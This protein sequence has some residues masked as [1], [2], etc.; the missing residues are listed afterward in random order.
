MTFVC[1]TPFQSQLPTLKM[2]GRCKTAFLSHL[3]S[4]LNIGAEQIERHQW[5]LQFIVDVPVICLKTSF[6]TVLEL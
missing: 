3:N 5:I 1:C 4:T 2:D 6:E